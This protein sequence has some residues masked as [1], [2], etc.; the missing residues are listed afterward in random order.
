MLLLGSFNAKM[1]I[2]APMPG[3]PYDGVDDPDL[4]F[5]SFNKNNKT[6]FCGAYDSDAHQ[7][8]FSAGDDV[9]IAHKNK[10]NGDTPLYN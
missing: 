1:T 2:A 8:V 9:R 6:E 7:F 10:F 5:G 3:Q 4:D